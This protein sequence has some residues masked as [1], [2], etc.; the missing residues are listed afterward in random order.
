M[1]RKVTIITVGLVV[2]I[3]LLFLANI[4]LGSVDIPIEEILKVITGDH[5]NRI[6][7]NI[8]LNTRLPQTVTALLAGA[9]LSVGGLQ[10]QTLFRNPL[11]G[12]SI[13]GISSGASL[14][15]AFVILLSGNIGGVALSK[16]GVV[17]SLAITLA[18]LTGSICVLLF[19]CFLARKVRGNATLLILGIMVGYTVSSIVSMLKFYSL[20]DDVHA[21]VIWGMGSFSKISSSQMQIFT[22]ILIIG[23]LSS[24]LLSKPLNLLMLGENYAKNL[25]VN[26][27]R[28]RLLII[29]SAGVLTAVVTAYCGPIMFIGLAVPHIAKLLYSSS[30]HRV[31][32]PATMLIG[33]S[34]ALLCN[35]IAR[36]PG[37]DGTLPIN[38]VTALIGAPVVVWVLLHKKRSEISE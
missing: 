35:L 4:G 16:M 33:S 2:V 26:I 20:E 7:T 25:G 11:A 30:D 8:I 23:L 10:M 17:G 18:A 31:T 3:I 28:T 15:V 13:L 36:M 32:I 24:I 27:E 38:S 34:I 19:V 6:W 22:P 12:P 29:A 21:Y 9:A 5:S 1:N 37:F 14:G